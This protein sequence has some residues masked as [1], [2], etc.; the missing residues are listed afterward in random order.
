VAVDAQFE[1]HPAT[2]LPVVAQLG[3]PSLK[4]VVRLVAILAACGG[5]LY[6]VYLAR[7]VLELLLIAAFTAMALAPVVDVVQRSGIGRAWAT[8][9]VYVACVLAV[10]G[11]GALVVPSVGS[12][13]GGLSRDAQRAVA[14]LRV[15][16]QVR[17]FDDRYHVTTQ[18]RRQL[19]HLPA[20]VSEAAGPLRKV[21]IG[22]IGY[23]SNAIAVLSIAFLLIVN[24]ERYTS[25]VLGLL[26]A[27]PAARWRRLAPQVYRAVSG[28][29]LGNLAISV[30][31]GVSAWVV[32]TLLGV[33][34]AVPLAIAMAFFDLIPMVGA[35]LGSIIIALA[36][37]LVSPL[38]AAIWLV[39]SFLY[40]QAESYLIGPVVYRRAVQVSPMVTILAVLVGAALLGLL[41]ALLAIPAAAAVQIVVDDLRDGRTQAP[42]VLTPPTQPKESL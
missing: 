38:A 7:N 39:F 22:A 33:P 16:A 31:A 42:V 6:L 26:A 14:D 20:R 30:I 41:G 9:V 28:Y 40:Q 18:I 21:T 8:G 23:V 10:I 12:Q 5:A 24:G 15:N 13:V 34:F 27:E 1:T 35:T 11:V 4:G 32:M 3:A 37:L 19:K 29:V 25:A 17:R 36:A 2:P